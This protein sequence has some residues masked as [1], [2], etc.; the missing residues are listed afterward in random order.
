MCAL[1]EKYLHQILQEFR[2]HVLWVAVAASTIDVDIDTIKLTRNSGCAFEST[3]ILTAANI[4]T[5][6][7]L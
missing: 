1:L 2:M 4:H 3:E 5:V 6:F 7:G